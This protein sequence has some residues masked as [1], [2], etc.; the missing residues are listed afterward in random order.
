[1]RVV[2]NDLTGERHEAPPL[3]LGESLDEHRELAL[4]LLG[5]LVHESSASLR[6]RD[7]NGP[8][9]P[10]ARGATDEAATFS[11]SDEPRDARLVELQHGGHGEHRGLPVAQDAEESN[12]D[13][14]EIMDVGDPCDGALH[15]E[16]ELH[17]AVGERQHGPGS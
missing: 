9:I 16:R 10:G 5:D 15:G 13:E 14:G 1:L 3:R 8:P 11:P 7:V 4:D 2:V 6:E 17:E 12:L